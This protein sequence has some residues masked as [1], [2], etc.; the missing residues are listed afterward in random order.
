LSP[1][2]VHAV[3][4]IDAHNRTEEVR[5]VLRIIVGIA[6]TAAIAKAYVQKSVRSKGNVAAVVVIKRLLQSQQNL[7]ASDTQRQAAILA[8]EA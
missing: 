4:D 7:L 2:G 3:I 5:R 8:H 1:N 6:A